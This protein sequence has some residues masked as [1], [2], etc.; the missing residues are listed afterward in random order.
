MTRTSL[1]P[2]A[3]LPA[4]ATGIR[5]LLRAVAVAACVPY[6]SLKIAWVAGSTIGI[7]DGSVLLDH[8]VTMAVANSVSVLMDS[9]VIVLALLLT[10]EWGKRV[11]G[12][13]LTVPVWVATGLL[14]PIMVGFPLQLITSGFGGAASADAPKE[15]FLDAWVFGVVYGGFILQ[16]LALGA[17]FLLYARDRWARVWQGRVRELP[18]PGALARSAAVAGSL[19]AVLPAVMHLLWLCGSTLALSPGR[20]D[21]RGT[22]F[23]LLEGVRLLFVVAAVAGALVLAFRRPRGLSVRAPLAVA[24]TGSGALGCWGGWLFAVALLPQDDATER[25]TGL[26]TLTYAVEMIAGILLISGVASLLR[27]RAA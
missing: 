8:R 26:L 1:A 13:L 15:A 22:D 21:D 9:V 5:T 2:R 24:W 19:A 18:A 7:P 27:R 6:L 12:P 17:L 23:H 16:G 4:P 20:I 14:S 3:S 10:Q 25:A 11:R